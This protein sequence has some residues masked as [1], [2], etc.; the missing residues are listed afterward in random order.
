M[1]TTY[2]V[3]SVAEFLLQ[4]PQSAGT[5]TGQGDWHLVVEILH[6]EPGSAL[7]GIDYWNVPVWGAID[8]QP[9]TDRVRGM[10]WMRGSDE[11]FG[12]PRVGYIALTLDDND[13]EMDPW[14]SGSAQYL[15]PGTV[16]RA[17]LTSATGI[18]DA[19]YGTVTWLPQWTGIVESWAPVIATSNAADRFVEVRLN[20]T[21]RDLSQIDEVALAAPVGSGE[22]S[23]ARAERL[24]T[25]ANWPY[26]YLLEAQ[27]L[28]P[29]PA[30][31]YPLQ[32]T[33]MAQNRLAELYLTADSSDSQFRSIRDGRASLTASEYISNRGDADADVWPLVL[34]SWYPES[35]Y[36]VPSVHLDNEDLTIDSG[37]GGLQQNVAFRPETFRSQSQDI[38]ISNIVT[39]SRV[40]GIPQQYRQEYSIERYGP[41]AYVRSDYLN[42]NDAITL[43]L[44]QYI[45]VRRALSTLRLEAVTVDTWARSLQSFLAVVSLEPTNRAVVRSPL[46]A[47]PRPEII[48]QV[49]SIVHRVSPRVS[50]ASLLWETD[51]RVDTRT[52][53]G[54]PG[55]QLPAS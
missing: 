1:T 35:G 36:R 55:A 30:T 10:E 12:R 20:E 17:G 42:T 52:I 28:V 2:G 14:T 44:A 41:R 39:I 45:S 27:Q 54:V 22:G 15:A 18:V 29:A 43:Q 34:T 31:M 24:L 6:P 53:Y 50:G 38:E 46:G 49:A 47:S 3:S 16:L 11:I 37:A 13:G 26:G 8:W 4:P 33:D 25:A 51:I 48:G 9:L 23:S 5:P 40:G 32:S 19:D 21:V 7:W